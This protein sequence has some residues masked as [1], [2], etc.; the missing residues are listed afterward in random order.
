MPSVDKPAQNS[1]PGKV[2]RRWQD[3]AQGQPH[4]ACL[5]GGHSLHVRA[6]RACYSPPEGTG[7]RPQ[8]GLIA[9]LLD[10]LSS[11][12][13]SLVSP[14]SL[15]K[16]R[17]PTLTGAPDAEPRGE[18]QAQIRPRAQ[19]PDIRSSPQNRRRTGDPNANPRRGTATVRSSSRNHE[20]DR[21]P[22]LQSPPRNPDV[23]ADT[24]PRT[25]GL[26]LRP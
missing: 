2:L 25:A 23:D 5:I 21:R 19:N 17:T 13:H 12:I 16:P 4:A 8:S 6:G 18:P 7:R 14:Y 10:L 15:E 9:N 3:T 24:G 20:A 26:G 1:L 11:E 22:E